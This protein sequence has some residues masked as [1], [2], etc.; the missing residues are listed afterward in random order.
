MQTLS[1]HKAMTS[2]SPSISNKGD[3]EEV[4]IFT[5]EGEY[6]ASIVKAKSMEEAEARY[7]NQLEKEL[8]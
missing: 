3:R 1:S 5:G 6:P 2:N 4:Y 8:S 7:R